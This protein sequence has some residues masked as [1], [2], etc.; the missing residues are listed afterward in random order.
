MGFVHNKLRN[1]LGKERVEN[2]VF[3]KT[4]APLLESETVSDWIDDEDEDGVEESAA[5][6][7]VVDVIELE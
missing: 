3:L 5:N 2:L 1:S 6:S 4:N 7:S